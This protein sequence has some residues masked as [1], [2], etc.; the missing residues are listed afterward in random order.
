MKHHG[1]I[2]GF[3]KKRYIDNGRGNGYDA[4]EIRQVE[5]RYNK[6]TFQTFV[7]NNYQI[8]DVYSP[9]DLPSAVHRIKEEGINLL[10]VNGGDGTMQRLI[11]DLIKSIPENDLPIILP[12]RGGT[13]NTIAGNI[14]VRKNPIDTVR[15]IMDHVEL[16]NRGEKTLS[17]LPLRP[18]KIT[19]KVHGTKY[20]FL[21]LNGL[22]HK[23]QQ[24]FYQQENPTFSTV[25]NL[26]TTMIG[27]YTI[28]NKNVTKYFSKTAAEIYI[29]SVKYP[30]EKHLLTIAS[31][32]QKLLLWFKPFYNPDAKGVDRFYFIATSA[33][34]WVIIKNLRIFSTG[35]QIPPRTFNDTAA[36][37]SIKAE[38]GYALD[39]EMIN[40]KHTELELDQG[41]LMKFLVVPETIRTSYGITYRAYFNESLVSMH[42][43]DNAPS[44]QAENLPG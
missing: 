9:T 30:E 23:V 40:D 12:L 36:H 17:T 3:Y 6:D 32:L 11:T 1:K 37:I 8:I 20:G 14:G 27:G 5:T 24:L 19:D 4:P 26:V 13:T 44:L 34:P 43:R 22:I 41:P 35:K 7:P 38:G 25:V 21:F 28:R 42:K 10:M 39:G 31:P 29:D 15:I 2:Q 33:D 16:Y 18:L